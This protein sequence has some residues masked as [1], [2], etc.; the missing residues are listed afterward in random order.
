MTCIVG[1][2]HEG[3][4]YLGGDSIASNLYNADIVAQ[5]KVFARDG[6]V[7]GYTSSFRFGQ[8]LEHALDVP[9]R[10]AD[11]RT[12]AFVFRLCNAIRDCL[13]EH[14]WMGKSEDRDAGGEAIVGVDGRLFVVQAD[15]AAVES[16]R[17]FAAVGSGEGFALGALV[18]TADWTDHRHRVVTALRAAATLAA[19]VRPPFTVI[20]VPKGGEPL[21]ETV[22]GA[23]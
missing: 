12:E 11:E 13:R 5:P 22:E 14:G 9:A 20:T 2:A 16:R 3:A 7:F 19:H 10:L 4:I 8:L 17:G 15:F 1:I 21:T 23:A 18:A 6:L